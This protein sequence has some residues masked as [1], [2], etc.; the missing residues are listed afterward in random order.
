MKAKVNVE[1]FTS[2]IEEQ[3]LDN[4]QEKA[5]RHNSNEGILSQDDD[6]IAEKEA[7]AVNSTHEMMDGQ[8]C[9]AEGAASDLS[10]SRE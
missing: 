9:C 2:S 7:E 6:P 1:T 8:V 10:L 3:L 4:S 5:Y